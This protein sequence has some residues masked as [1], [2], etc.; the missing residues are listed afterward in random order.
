M[1]ASVPE[2]IPIQTF[3]ESIPPH[4]RR[5]VQ[6]P[7]HSGQHGRMVLDWPSI[8]LF[9][10]YKECKRIGRFD[11]TS[12]ALEFF[13]RDNRHFERVFLTYRCRNC[14]AVIKTYALELLFRNGSD[15]A[16]F[17]KIGEDPR[18][19]EPRLNMVGDVLDDE[20]EMFDRGYRSELEG[21]G[22]G[23]FAYYRRF[24]ESHKD[25]IISE[26]RKVAVSQNLPQSILEALDRAATIREFSAAVEAIKE[27]I[28]DSIRINGANPLTLLHGALSAGIHNE[29]DVDCL[30][31]AQDI[32]LILT[33]LAERT[34]QA[35]KSTTELNA[36]VTRLNQR[37][38]ARS[39]K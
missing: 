10:G 25:K 11:P 26:I 21:L 6:A 30:S 16:S 17:E 4:E 28:P 37:R 1:A 35:L 38:S 20:I 18:F 15:N 29:D 24:V 32:R 22:I 27:A 36:A 9:C 19:G 13:Y 3:L 7:V 12:E 5:V 31:I 8:V 23:A 34:S 2:S 14:E 39:S 33:E